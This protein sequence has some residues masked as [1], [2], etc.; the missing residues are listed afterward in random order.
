MRT[1][2]IGNLAASARRLKCDQVD[3]R[4]VAE[5]IFPT[6]LVLDMLRRLMTQF[7]IMGSRD[8]R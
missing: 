2:R 8:S 6:L 5:G 3:L 1:I 4:T 7:D